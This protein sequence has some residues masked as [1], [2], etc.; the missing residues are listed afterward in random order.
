[1]VRAPLQLIAR[2]NLLCAYKAVV[3]DIDC[4]VKKQAHGT[5]EL[6]TCDQIKVDVRVDHADHG[7]SY[8]STFTSISVKVSTFVYYY[9]ELSVTDAR[10]CQPLGAL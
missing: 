4:S 1:M 5:S 8:Q 10:H 7:F 9:Q 6:I 3:S 2:G